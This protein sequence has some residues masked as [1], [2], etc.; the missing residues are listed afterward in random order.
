V[1]GSAVA[2]RRQ[3][4]DINKCNGCHEFLSLHGEN[5]NQIEQ[6]VLCH[7]PSETDKAR[8]GSA[9]NPADKEQPPQAINFA[10]MIHRIHTGE[11]LAEQGAGYT[12]VGFGGSHND[13]S[14]VR[15]PAFST[16]GSPGDTR[17]CEM[18]HVNGSEQNLPTGKNAM[19]HPQGPWSPMG[20]VAA[21][22]TG[23]HA[24]MPAASHALA[25]TTT[26]GESCAACH[27]ANADFNVTRVH[28]Q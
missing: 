8:R 21:A 24:S 7:N 28:A 10:Y 16:S 18:C 22:C 27:D 2:P 9:Q 13:F 5:R 25:N 1:D 12:V 23:C 6:C 15:Y 14:E 3:V 19:T 20:A 26:L 4:V 17:N 11:N